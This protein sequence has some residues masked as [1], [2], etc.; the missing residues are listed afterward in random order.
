MFHVLKKSFDHKK[1]VV[2]LEPPLDAN[3]RAVDFEHFGRRKRTRADAKMRRAPR[4]AL[5]YLL[6]ILFY[7]AVLCV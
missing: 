2:P 4:D 5:S 3:G 7:A 6:P 1:C